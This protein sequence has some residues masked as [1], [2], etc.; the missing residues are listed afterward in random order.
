MPHDFSTKSGT[1][2]DPSLLLVESNVSRN[3]SVLA[4]HP[5]WL[6]VDA[7]ELLHAAEHGVPALGV[8]GHSEESAC[9]LD[10]ILRHGVPS[11]RVEQKFSSESPIVPLELCDAISEFTR[12][13]IFVYQL[14]HK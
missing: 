5:I 10:T 13:L 7:T 6:K 11:S 1:P 8:R 2:T 4:Q 12:R 14:S 3:K 9:R